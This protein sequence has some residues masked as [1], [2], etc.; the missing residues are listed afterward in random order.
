VHIPGCTETSMSGYKC[1]SCS[2]PVIG[3]STTASD[4]SGDFPWWNCCNCASS[5]SGWSGWPRRACPQCRQRD[6]AA[7]NVAENAS[8]ANE[9]ALAKRKAAENDR[10]S[11]SVT[12]GQARAGGGEL[13]AS[14]VLAEAKQVLPCVCLIA[15]LLHC[16]LDTVRHYSLRPLC[17][18]I[19]FSSPTVPRYGRVYW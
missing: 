6:E 11:A 8:V 16:P 19:E 14:T 17:L 3:K 13:E 10:R 2:T 9:A 18:L 5:K 7:G 12:R 1:K 4:C 15:S